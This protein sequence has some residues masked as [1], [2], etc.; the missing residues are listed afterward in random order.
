[1]FVI[2]FNHYVDDIDP[3]VAWCTV[4]RE[5]KS[6]RGDADGGA[7]VARLMHIWT[8]QFS[9]VDRQPC[10]RR[11]VRV[12]WVPHTQRTLPRVLLLFRPRPTLQRVDLPSPTTLYRL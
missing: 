10:A 12:P 11:A 3:T 5:Q 6:Q 2:S 7:Q 4:P 9:L 8:V 1:M